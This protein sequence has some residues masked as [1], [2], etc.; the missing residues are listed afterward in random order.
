MD[1][2]M[3][4]IIKGLRSFFESFRVRV[5][6]ALVCGMLLM[7]LMAG[8]SVQRI[9]L[10]AQLEQLRQNLKILA[11][12]AA[13]T[14]DPEAVQ[15]IPLNRD[16]V[17]TEA[18]R[19]VSAKLD[20]I[21]QDNPLIG[22][23]YVMTRAEKEGVLKFVAD[24]DPFLS[25]RG[26]LTAYPGDEY[27]IRPFPQMLEA[28]S[29]AVVDREVNED[30]WGKILSGYA[31]ILDRQGKAVAILG[32][33]ILAS[34]IYATQRAINRRIWYVLLGGVFCS[35][36]FGLWFSIKI[37]KPVK[38]L[39]DGI[40]GV[41]K[42]DLQCRV[43]VSG[44]DEISEL[45]LSFNRMAEAL[46][47]A[48]QKNQDYFYGVMQSLVR[49]VEAR[50]AYTCGHSERVAEY[51]VQ[52]ARRLGLMPDT[53]EIL[54]QAAV[55]HDIGK[56]G[57]H[58]EVLKKSEKLTPEEWELI[59]QHP[60][61]GEDILRPVLFDEEILAVVRGHHERYDGKGYPDRLSGEHINILTQILSIADAYDAMTSTRPYREPLSREEAIRELRGNRN[62]QFSARITDVFI[63]VLEEKKVEV[64]RG[65]L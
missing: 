44:Q 22:F 8:F 65:V 47:L 3:R 14:V 35:L 23:V 62:R 28:F 56:L 54:R 1:N 36:L 7:V 25:R 41:S 53:V 26:G 29:G 18:Y 20:Q 11:N 24:A 6:L 42:G 37:T 15:A 52:I 10:Q 13:L 12:I 63:E 17:Y 31:P 58:E 60:V 39:A 59:R 9:A 4:Q 5:T 30:A 48:Q 45:S 2:K 32:I 16:G 64:S 21:K 61:I 34:D 38:A 50:D 46:R 57:I 19:S 33:D 55:L 43:K 51:A 40:R 27:D 49:I